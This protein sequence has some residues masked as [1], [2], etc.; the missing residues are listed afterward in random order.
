MNPS[1]A[2]PSEVRVSPSPAPCDVPELESGDRL[3]RDDFERRYAAMPQLKKA[4]LIE[5][6]CT[7]RRPLAWTSMPAPT[8]I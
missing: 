5:E 3:T 6:W 4:E 7:C 2:G 1:V 8:R